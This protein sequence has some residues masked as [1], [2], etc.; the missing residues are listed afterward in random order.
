MDPIRLVQNILGGGD[1]QR[2]RLDIAELELRQA[3]LVRRRREVTEVSASEVID[4][5]LGWE[6]LERRVEL[7]VSQLQNRTQRET[8]M[9]A[10][11]RT[12]AGSTTSM[13]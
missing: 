7:L 13:L 2:D 5:V 3:N 8:V 6:R 11:Y 4:L 1:V 9:E 12:G 10:V